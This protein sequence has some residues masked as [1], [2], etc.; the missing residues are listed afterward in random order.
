MVNKNSHKLK[1]LN[2]NQRCQALVLTSLKTRRTCGDLIQKYKL[3][4]GIYEIIWQFEPVLLPL[5]G[6]HRGYYE[7]E[8]IK[9]SDQRFYFLNNRTAQDWNYLTDEIV[10]ANSTNGFK[11]KL[12]VYL[13]NVLN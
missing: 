5:R 6:C 1:G 3:I 2:Y 8:L 12:D 4:N 10:S 11:N 9:D 13:L 7:R